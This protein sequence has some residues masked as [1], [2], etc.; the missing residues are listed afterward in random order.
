M[1]R[2]IAYRTILSLLVGIFIAF[3][4]NTPRESISDTLFTVLGI[5]YSIVMSLLITFSTTN[6][7]KTRYRKKIKALI[8]EKIRFTTVDFFLPVLFYTLSCLDNLSLYW[9]K[10]NHFFIGS[11]VIS[12]SSLIRVFFY[13]RKLNDDIEEKIF[14]EQRTN[15]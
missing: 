2:A 6:I 1:I 5:V 12:L 10:P 11:I 4:I 15:P 7:K 3:T 14:E 13:I 9:I 8:R